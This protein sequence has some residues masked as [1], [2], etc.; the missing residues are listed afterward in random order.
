MCGC[1]FGSVCIVFDGWRGWKICGDDSRG[2]GSC[3]N[4]V[5]DVIVD[6]NFFW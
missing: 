1:G 4:K 5:V 3:L 6:D 2:E